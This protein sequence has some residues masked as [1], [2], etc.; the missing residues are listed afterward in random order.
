M[1]GLEATQSG[2]HSGPIP[3][4]RNRRHL[5]SDGGADDLLQIRSEERVPSDA[6]ARGGPLQDGILG[7]QSHTLVMVGGSLRLEECPTIFPTEDGRGL[8]GSFILT[9]LH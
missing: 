7:S 9:M 5:Q 1:W 3:L 6:S 2:D 8:E 4:T